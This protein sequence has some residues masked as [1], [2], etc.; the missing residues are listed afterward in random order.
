MNVN[1]SF[2]SLSE[3]RLIVAGRDAQ[4][5]GVIGPTVLVG[6]VDVVGVAGVE[7]E[8]DTEVGAAL[9]VRHCE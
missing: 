9:P 7:A 8:V 2:K 6:P 1:G 5:E 3:T 4:P